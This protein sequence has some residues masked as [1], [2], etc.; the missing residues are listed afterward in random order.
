LRI[1]LNMVKV[2]S[3]SLQR[4]RSSREMLAGSAS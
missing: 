1:W 4:S 2:I 3:R